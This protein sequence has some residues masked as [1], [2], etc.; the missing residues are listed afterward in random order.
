MNNLGPTGVRVNTFHTIVQITFTT[1]CCSVLLT[2]QCTYITLIPNIILRGIV[3][4][5]FG[6]L[7]NM[8]GNTFPRSMRRVTDLPSGA[9]LGK[10]SQNAH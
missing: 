10:V 6:A 7:P 2:A 8:R 9:K 1:F 5:C 3:N 4:G